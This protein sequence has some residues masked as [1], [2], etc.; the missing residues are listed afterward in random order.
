MQITYLNHC[1]IALDIKTVKF[2][3]LNINNLLSKPAIQVFLM[4][5]Y[6][7]LVFWV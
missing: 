2:C 5:V 4:D 6:T 7:I 1:R 3:S